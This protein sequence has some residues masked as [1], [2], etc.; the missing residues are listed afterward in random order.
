MNHFI[1]MTPVACTLLVGVA[2][3]TACWFDDGE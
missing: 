2:V 1:A 3:L